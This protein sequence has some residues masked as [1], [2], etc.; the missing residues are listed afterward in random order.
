MT[1]HLNFSPMD[2]NTI[3]QMIDE[4]KVKTLTELHDNYL[5][6]CMNAI[7]FNDDGHTVNQDARELKLFCAQTI[8]VNYLIFTNAWNR[9]KYSKFCDFK[10]TY[11]SNRPQHFRT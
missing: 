1:I 5:L 8:Q 4:N 7:M 11:L 6:M 10:F 2:L 9:N 3:K